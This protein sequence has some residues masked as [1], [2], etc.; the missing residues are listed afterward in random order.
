MGV[1]KSGAK[2]VTADSIIGTSGR[3][4]RLWAVNMLSGT[5][6]ELVLRNGTTS[7]GTVWICEQGTLNTGKT[8]QY[9]KEGILF[10]NGMFYDDDANFT[11]VLIQYSEEL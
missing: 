11:E 1:G 2:W 4:I 9:G 10:P 8:V 7:S 5:A 6:G 3:P